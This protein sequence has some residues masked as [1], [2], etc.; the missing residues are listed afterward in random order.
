MRR[1]LKWILISNTI[2][3]L[4]IISQISDLF[5]LINDNPGEDII[6]DPEI[7]SYN[8]TLYSSSSSSTPSIN[9]QK[10][11]KIIHQTY[12]TDKI[13]SKWNETFYSCVK[14]YNQD[15]KYMFWTD[16]N[17]R[18]FIKKNYKWFL[19]TFDNYKYPIQRAD[20]LRYFVLAHYGGVYIDLDCG[21]K[22]DID[23]LLQF[24][25]FVRKTDPGISN[26][27]MGSVPKHPFFL[28]VIQ[29]L[30]KYNKNWFIS[31]LTVM[32][33]TGPL[34]LSVM[35]HKYKK[36]GYR[37]DWGALR[38][39]Y[40]PN[41]RLKTVG[42]FYNKPGS[43]WHSSD[44]SLV[45][46]MGDHLVLTIIV[47]TLIVSFLL[48]QQYKFYKMLANAN[49]RRQWVNYTMRLFAGAAKRV[50]RL[51]KFGSGTEKEMYRE[52]AVPL[53]QGQV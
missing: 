47:I 3:L 20:S 9:Q 43:S 8:R 50:L 22:T 16:K 26:D 45:I 24:P 6:L 11:P 23:S 34:F 4:Y 13:P 32:Y 12:K 42:I 5:M 2:L 15:Y 51:F 21:C 14:K 17:A 33:T 27:V 25:A 1:E 10:I 31:Y 46:F 35:Y 44:A 36:M 41:N 52:A 40:P 38:V 18:Q 19:K 49:S 48:Y 7:A 30:K 39:L 28:N 29:N 37:S 53:G